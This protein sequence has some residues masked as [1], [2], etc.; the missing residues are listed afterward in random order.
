[1]PKTSFTPDWKNIP[2]I[3]NPILSALLLLCLFSTIT[4]RG[5]EGAISTAL[6]DF[7]ELYQLKGNWKGPDDGPPFYERFEVRND[8]LINITHFSDE[9]FSTKV[10]T[11]TLSLEQGQVFHTSGNS[12]WRVYQKEGKK[13]FFEPIENA[14]N[15]FHWILEGPSKWTAV[16]GEKIYDMQKVDPLPKKEK[17]SNGQGTDRE[18]IKK[19]VLDYVEG[20]YTA[21][22]MRIYA[23]VHPDLIKRGTFINRET[24]MYSSFKDMTF[25]ELIDLSENWNKEGTRA[26]PGSIKKVEIYDVQDKTAAA[27]LT[28]VWGSDYIH[29]AKIDGKWMIMN[30]LWQTPNPK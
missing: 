10:G 14:R 29:L 20:L 1:M 25:K 9:K 18:Q 21:D 23:S 11:G 22:T 7:S 13:W 28:A 15:K 12:K 16:V 4:A 3:K 24:Q 5:Q 30:V 6:F 8:S 2:T 17:S 27:K 19:A 26:D